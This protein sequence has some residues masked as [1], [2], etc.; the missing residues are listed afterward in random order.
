VT[1]IVSA[2]LDAAPELAV[3][4]WARRRHLILATVELVMLEIQP[5]AIGGGAADGGGYML[6]TDEMITLRD[7]A[8]LDHPDWATLSHHPGGGGG[9]PGAVH[10]EAGRA[11]GMMD[12]NGHGYDDDAVERAMS[13]G[14]AVGV[15]GVAAEAAE[16]VV[17]LVLRELHLSLHPA[18]AA[19]SHN[20]PGATAGRFLPDW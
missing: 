6:S 9:G 5:S 4:L 11:R 17:S 16:C 19:A 14:M 15:A 8:V 10:Y 18:A 7:R 12:R 1:K 20:D 3:R 2:D 13:M